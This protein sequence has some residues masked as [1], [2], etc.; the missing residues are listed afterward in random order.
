MN[1]RHIYHAGN[2]AD[3]FKH[4][5]LTLILD[6]LCVKDAP[7]CLLDTHAALGF[8][9]LQHAHAQKTQEYKSG[10]ARVLEHSPTPAFR[11]YVDIVNKYQHDHNAYPGSGAIMHE[12]LRDNDRLILNELHPE[13]YQALIDNF[14]GDKRVKIMQQDAY[15]CIKALLP[16]KERRGLILIDP[17]FEK[18]DEL[19]KIITS[20]KDGLQRFATGI[21]AVWYPIKDRKQIAKFYRD[22]ATL[23]LKNSLG[24]ELHANDSIL[25]QLHS[26]GMIIINSPWKLR[27]E[28]EANLPILI[29]YLE[30]SKGTYKLFDFD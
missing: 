24:I 14:K 19:V 3:V 11:S 26:C 4:W 2:F 12:Y 21:Y 6:K 16:P 23:D 9:D 28:L 10:I 17:P 29:K 20:I 22:L 13:D 8:Y 18:T 5:I 15:V 1:Y 7:F 30:L 25:D 27:E